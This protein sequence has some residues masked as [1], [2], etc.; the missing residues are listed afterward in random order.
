[1][2]KSKTQ[3]RGNV[4]EVAENTYTKKF[5]PNSNSL[6]LAPY[7]D[8]NVDVVCDLTA[9]VS[10]AYHQIADCF[11][12]VQTL[13][14]IYE[15]KEA[16][17]NIKKLMKPNGTILITVASVCQISEFDA[18]RWGDYFR[19]TPQ[20]FTKLLNES[21][22]QSKISI[23]SFGNIRAATGL[24][25]GLVVEDINTNDLLYKDPIYPVVLTAVVQL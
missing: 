12:C 8:K 14:F 7:E 15:Y 16:L 6:I 25:H 3:L 24:L 11:I 18:Q 9:T 17:K 4:L 5:A 23:E 22:P 19:F 1:M 2:E 10:P 21:F 20:S 13:N